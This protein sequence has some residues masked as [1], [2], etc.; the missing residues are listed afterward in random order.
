MHIGIGDKMRKHEFQDVTGTVCYF[1][2]G[3]K[4][5][6]SDST[7][8]VETVVNGKFVKLGTVKVDGEFVRRQMIE[9]K[10]IKDFEPYD[11]AK[12]EAHKHFPNA[13][14]IIVSQIYLDKQGLKT[15]RI[16][17]NKGRN[18]L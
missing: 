9:H 18:F 13:N 2:E 8:E 1:N 4:G 7:W 3:T 17:A 12:T 14:P 6:I 10:S 11:I 15:T 5:C 16:E